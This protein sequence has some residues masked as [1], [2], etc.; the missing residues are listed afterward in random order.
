MVMKVCPNCEHENPSTANHCMICGALLVDE[1]QLPEEVLLK[2]ELGEARETIVLL[3]KSLAVLQEKSRK[4]CDD[5]E[6]Q[7]L[8]D[9]IENCNKT[10]ELLSRRTNDQ[11]QDI[12]KLTNQLESEKKKKNGGKW[13][14]FFVVFCAFL[15]YGVYKYREYYM[16]EKVRADN[17][18]NNESVLEKSKSK[19][20]NEY[21]D[22]R[23][24]YDT[25]SAKYPIIIN[26]V[27]IANVYGDGM[28]ETDYGGNIYSSNT[29]FLKPRISYEG[30]VDTADMLLKV[31]WYCDGDFLC[32]HNET[33]SVEK[34]SNTLGLSS[35]GNGYEGRWRRG[36]YRVEFW[37][38]G[39]ALASKSFDI[40]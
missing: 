4:T 37:S 30:F 35:H 31:K 38:R 21:Y 16:Y 36:Y 10:I 14:W 2:R 25:L 17:L 29:M 8:K 23:S 5:A 15:V 9:Q 7:R 13:G 11:K 27:E 24:D 40:Y 39:V 18:A 20:E 19:L 12:L 34:G 22:L 1:E 28:I 32:S 33:I 26:N 6:V 3:K